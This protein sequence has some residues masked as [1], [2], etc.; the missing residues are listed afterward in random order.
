MASD[1]GHLKR[2]MVSAYSLCDD[3]FLIK[4]K[5]QSTHSTDDDDADEDG[6]GGGFDAGGRWAVRPAWNHDN[7]KN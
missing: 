4:I 6:D 5:M 7:N 1:D 3:D 2:G